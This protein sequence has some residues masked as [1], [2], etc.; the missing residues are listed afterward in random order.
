MNKGW[1]SDPAAR[2][3]AT[4]WSAFKQLGK[5]EYTAELITYLSSDA[6]RWTTGQ[7]IDVTGG[8]QI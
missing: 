3:F 1:L 8:T 7:I 5:P 2:D 6:S 4:N